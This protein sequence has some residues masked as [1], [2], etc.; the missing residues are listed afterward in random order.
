MSEVTVEW[1]QRVA[2][3]HPGLVETVELTDF[4]Q[5]CAKN[6]RLVII[7]EKLDPIINLVIED[8][9]TPKL[10]EAINDLGQSFPADLPGAVAAETPKPGPVA[11]RPNVKPRPKTDGGGADL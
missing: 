8:N 6:G 1:T 10:E 4:I 11:T 2:G 7:G 3:R 5:G 9:L